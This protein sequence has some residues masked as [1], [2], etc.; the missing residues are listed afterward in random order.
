MT[1]PRAN[2][3]IKSTMDGSQLTLKFVTVVS[4]S[5]V[6]VLS[7]LNSETVVTVIGEVE[8]V[9]IVMVSRSTLIVVIV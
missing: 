9:I 1:A 8:V 3:T 2:P 4:L 7:I 5:N 6:N